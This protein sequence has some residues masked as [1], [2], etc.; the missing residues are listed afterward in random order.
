MPALSG[1]GLD[2]ERRRVV[3]E[4]WRRV[5]VSVIVLRE[6]APRPAIRDSIAAM[7]GVID[8]SDAISRL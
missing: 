2:W 6:A 4:V 5:I 3:E 8:G 7:A 1:M